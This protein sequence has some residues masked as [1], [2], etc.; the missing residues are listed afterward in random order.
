MGL[1]DMVTGFRLDRRDQLN[2]DHHK[3]QI[4][5]T[6][7]FTNEHT[8]TNR[9]RHFPLV[10]IFLP[11]TSFSLSLSLPLTYLP[12][13]SPGSVRLLGLPIVG[14]VRVGSSP[15]SIMSSPFCPRPFRASFG[16]WLKMAT[17]CLSSPSFTSS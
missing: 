7:K 12:F 6:T 15:S 9:L 16:L 13:Y 10:S 4:K 17:G 14:T 11:P 5:G 2:T 8:S 1:Q 3:Y